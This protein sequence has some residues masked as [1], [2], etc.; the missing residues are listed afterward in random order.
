MIQTLKKIPAIP[1]D[2]AGQRFRS[3]LE[4]KWAAFFDLLGWK[5]EYEPVDLA[6]WIPDFRIQ[7]SSPLLVEVK[8]LD[9]LS[10]ES[11]EVQE[12]TQAKIMKAISGTHLQGQSVLL[13]GSC[14]RKGS[15]PWASSIEM[16]EF[17]SLGELAFFEP[18]GPCYVWGPAPFGLTYEKQRPDISEPWFGVPTG[19]LSGEVLWLAPSELPSVAALWRRAG[20]VVQYKRRA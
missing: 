20:D 7:A 1:T 19:L 9:W 4:A 12:E 2:Y 11:A 14:L 15:F 3:R 6:G 18:G 16:G 5:W 13:V 8:P 17:S 10:E